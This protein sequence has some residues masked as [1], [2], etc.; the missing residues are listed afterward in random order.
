[1]KPKFVVGVRHLEDGNELLT[2]GFD[3]ELVPNQETNAVNIGYR[4]LRGLPAHPG[5]ALIVHSSFRRSQKTAKMVADELRLRGVDVTVRFE[6][7]LNEFDQGMPKFPQ[8]YKNGDHLPS[9]PL[10]WDEFCSQ[11]Y[12]YN[13]L[14]YKFGSGKMASQFDRFGESL[15]DVLPRQYCFFERLLSGELEAQYAVVILCCH[16]TTL[17]IIAE[18]KILA[19]LLEFNTM[20]GD[21]E[22]MQLPKLCWQLFKAAKAGGSFPKNIAF[23][24]VMFFDLGPIRNS[25]LPAKVSMAR[26]VFERMAA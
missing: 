7:G 24:E 19:V 18:L 9:L 22:P 3:A 14:R 17:H 25:I 10:A 23:G 20:S 26:E 6:E 2:S 15:L 12:V 13:N 21:F 5:T 8:G 1:M 16:T 11:A 4:I